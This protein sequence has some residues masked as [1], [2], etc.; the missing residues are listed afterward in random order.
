M[1]R[2]V[3]GGVS[4][5]LV[6]ALFHP[7]AGSAG[8]TSF[9]AN[10]SGVSCPTATF[11]M[12]VGNPSDEVQPLAELW[13]GSTWTIQS[14][15][16][17]TQDV[18]TFAAVSCSSSTA[19]TAVGSF[20]GVV[21]PQLLADRWNGKRWTIESMPSP[22]GFS[23]GSLDGVA[24]PS[25]S[26]CIAVGPYQ[27]TSG[28]AHPLIEAWNGS[29]WKVQSA[30][31]L[32]GFR[33]VGLDGIACASVKLCTTVGSAVEPSGTSV[34]V[35]ER[36]SNSQWSIQNTPS[37]ALSSTEPFLNLS[38]V[39]C[40]S[41]TSCTAV[42]YYVNT[43]GVGASLAELWNGL[44]WGV[45]STPNPAGSSTTNLNGVACTAPNNCTAVGSSLSSSGAS[46]PLVESVASKGWGVQTPLVPAGGAT[47]QFQAIACPSAA[48]CTAT[49]EYS[50][51][52]DP[53]SSFTLAE[54]VTNATWF[55][56]I[57][58][59]TDGGY[60]WAQASCQGT[61]LSSGGAL[62]CPN[63]NWVYQSSGLYDTWGY[64]FR[65]CTSWVAWRIESNNGY[66]MPTA[67]GDA[68]AWGGYFESH[69]VVV[70]ATP[71]VGSIAWDPGAGKDH[72]AYVE[73]VSS[74]GLHVTLSEY[75]EL[76][77]PGQPTTGDGLFDLRTVSTSAYKYIHVKDL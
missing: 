43:A 51:P 37:I 67:I 36:W 23:S 47:T 25:S 73:A 22:S 30:P 32:A 16:L 29:K 9:S 18:G 55:L 31:K 56:Q 14:T 27:D 46:L 41:T 74:D 19:C 35:V 2:R 17:P 12:A 61:P 3:V 4:I 65:N 13:N 68:S 7:I 57:A 11:C 40:P 59:P 75:N 72:V 1:K 21:P 10:L 24:C 64:N 5:T 52:N 45:Q 34:A 39:S 38:G 48:R 42:G 50:D 77:Y 60:L 54:K 44:Q 70:N 49:G 76:F 26:L 69:G 53:N 71:A 28:T 58:S 33:D 66:T 6:V 63:D 8:G 15:P 62:Y 20:E